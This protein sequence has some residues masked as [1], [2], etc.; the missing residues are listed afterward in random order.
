MP[1]TLKDKSFWKRRKMLPLSNNIYYPSDLTE[2]AQLIG[3][4]DGIF[5][6]EDY[7]LFYAEG[8]DTY[9]V[10]SQTYNNLYDSKSYYYITT[11]GGDGKG[12]RKQTNPMVAAT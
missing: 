3:E 4:N 11:S 1:P 10:E 2:N 7:I 8:I 5:D 6:N 9:N 12:L